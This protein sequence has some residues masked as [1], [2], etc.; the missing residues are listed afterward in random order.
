MYNLIELAKQ[1]DKQSL[2]EA[3]KSNSGLVWSVVK[4]FCGRG[5]E[6]EDLYQL[7]VIGLIKAIR[8]FDTSYE[9][10]FSTYAVPLITGEIKR[11]LRDDGMV[12]V[13]R[14]YKE[15]ASK[16]SAVS[17]RLASE[18]LCAPSM[19][20]IAGELGIDVYLLTE[21]MEAC[22]PCDSIYRTVSEEGKG[23]M[24]LLDKLL[25]EDD[26]RLADIASLRCAMEALS[27]RERTVIVCRYFMDETQS[28]V[29]SRLG[30]SQVQISR[31]EKKILNNLRENLKDCC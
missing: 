24:Y 18:K 27:D 16:A 25:G 11:F 26:S 30:I 22:T 10:K 15:I 5:H 2:E 4:R 23:E 13:S 21:A 20:E 29:A 3:V 14:R 7:G 6:P 9:V 8:R 31:M 17:L 19:S 28:K 1:G 12:K